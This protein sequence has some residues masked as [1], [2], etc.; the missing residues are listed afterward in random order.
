MKR[1]VWTGLTLAVCVAGSAL[2]ASAT[3]IDQ[4]RRQVRI[5]RT[6]RLHEQLR[7]RSLQ[8]REARRERL[9]ESRERGLRQRERVREQRL[10][11]AARDRAGRITRTER[12]RL[13]QELRRVFRDIWR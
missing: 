9:A 7:E 5:E 8:R 10:E 6:E 3:S 4:P 11:R 13:R 12:L 2:S 1:I